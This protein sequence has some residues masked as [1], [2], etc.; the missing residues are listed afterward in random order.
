MK[1]DVEGA[2]LGVLRGAREVLKKHKPRIF[3][4]VH[5]EQICS[6]GGSIAE[7]QQE[8]SD[9]NYETFNLDKILTSELKFGEYLLL[10]NKDF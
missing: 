3:L 6:L 4:S 9:L 10:P 8:L 1:I 2:E 7:L 5:P